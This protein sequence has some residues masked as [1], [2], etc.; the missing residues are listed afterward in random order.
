VSEN[1]RSPKI[2]KTGIIKNQVIQIIS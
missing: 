1:N 2:L